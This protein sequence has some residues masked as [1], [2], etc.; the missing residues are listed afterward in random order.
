MGD[1]AVPSLVDLMAVRAGLLSQGWDVIG[2]PERGELA[3]R[4]EHP[5]PGSV[6]SLTVDRS[7]RFRFTATRLAQPPDTRQVHLGD[8]VYRVLREQQE[9]LI[10]LGALR[11]AGELSQLLSDLADLARANTM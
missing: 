5:A 3:A 9:S 8:R 10:I 2:G 11:S 7:G 1:A 6:W 4:L